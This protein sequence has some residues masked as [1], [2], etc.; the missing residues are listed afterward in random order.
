[1]RAASTVALNLLVRIHVFG[2]VLVVKIS[3]S[4][5]TD[6]ITMNARLASEIF[7]SSLQSEFFSN[8]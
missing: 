3:P 1:V 6:T 2:R 4:R 8:L 7:L 5:F